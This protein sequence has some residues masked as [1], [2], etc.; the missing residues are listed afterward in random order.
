LILDVRSADEYKAGHVPGS[1]NIPHDKIDS[2]ADELRKFKR[3]FVHCQAGGRAGRASE[4]LAKL[5]LTNIICV[6][7]SGMGDW[8]ASG[9]PVE[10]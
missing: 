6:S 4:V 1:R 8:I 7:G 9:F 2:F 10:K 5:G 3:I